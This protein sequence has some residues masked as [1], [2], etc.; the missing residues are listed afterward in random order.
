MMWRII[1]LNAARCNWEPLI[2]CSGTCARN[3]FEP[4]TAFN[5]F[6]ISSNQGAYLSRRSPPT[7]VSALLSLRRRVCLGCDTWARSFLRSRGFDDRLT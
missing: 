2:F 5:L 1:G 4:V 6:V 3:G 7:L